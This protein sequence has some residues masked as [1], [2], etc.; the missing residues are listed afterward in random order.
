[1]MGSGLI[2]ELEGDG[3]G[4]EGLAALPLR[5]IRAVK[6]TPGESRVQTRVSDSKYRITPFLSAE[7]ALGGGWKNEDGDELEHK[8]DE[9]EKKVGVE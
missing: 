2:S 7:D 1:M 9:E 4:G 6:S 8:G 3:P 5:G